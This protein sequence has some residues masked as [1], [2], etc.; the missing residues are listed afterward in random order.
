MFKKI[1]EKWRK[2]IEKNA[3]KSTLSYK[4][5]KGKVYTEEVYLKRSQPPF[6]EKFGDWGRIYPPI[7]EDGT[8]NILN[9]LIGGWRNAIKLGLLLL[10]VM[11]VLF[12]FKEI[13]NVNELLRQTC[14]YLN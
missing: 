5:R 11:L 10:I 1:K 3:F 9:L 12:Q 2:K 6:I 7:N 8:L 4:D 14:M 13:F